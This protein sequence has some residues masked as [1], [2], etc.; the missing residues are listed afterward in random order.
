MSIVSSAFA[1]NEAARGGAIAF[2]HGV[3]SMS[4]CRLSGNQASVSGGAVYTNRATL[5][6]TN[7]TL[8]GNQAKEDGGAIDVMRSRLT[9]TSSSLLNNSAGYEGGGLKSWDDSIKI[10]ESVISGNTA[11]RDGGGIHSQAND[12]TIHASTIS[13]NLGNAGGGLYLTGGSHLISGSAFS[14]NRAAWYGGAI[15][16]EAEGITIENSTFYRNRAVDRVGGLYLRGASDLRH[17]T[18]ARN[19]AAEVGGL[20]LSESDADTRLVNSL[21]AGNSNGDCQGAFTA[22]INNLIED[23]TCNPELRGDARLA[24]LWGSP[25]AVVPADHSPAVDAGDP[26][27]CIDSDQLGRQRVWGASCDLG[28]FEVN[29][30]QDLALKSLGTT[31]SYEAP[32]PPQDPSAGIVVN[33]QCSLADAIKSAN[34]GWAV[35]GCPAGKAGADTITLT[36]NVTLSDRLPGIGSNITIEGAGHTISGANTFPIFNVYPGPLTVNDLTMTEG[37]GVGGVAIE[38]TDGVIT[39]NRSKII[40]N[41]S[42]GHILSSGGGIFCFPCTLIIRDS[43]I[44]NNSTETNGGG[45]AWHGFKE[46]EYLEIVDS[47]IDGNSARS[48][49]GLYISSPDTLQQPTIRNTTISNNVAKDDGGGIEAVVSTGMAYLDISHSAIIGNRAGGNGGGIIN[50]GVARLSLVTVAGNAADSGGGI[51]SAKESTTRLTH[52]TVAGNTADSG[53]GIYTQDEGTIQLRFSIIAGNSGNDCVGSPEHSIAG[54]IGDGSCNSMLKGDPLLA[55]LVMPAD[56]GPAYL[57]LMP[58]SPAIDAAFDAQCDGTDQI[59]R[60]RPQGRQCDL[61]AIEY[62]P[63]AEVSN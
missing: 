19:I 49:G 36:A 29:P 11:E 38:S 53:G 7:A 31:D 28:A 44:A 18:I 34:R 4:D 32:P 37:R 54:F 17:V 46:N 58:G 21:L 26:A 59:G 2:S 60:P 15:V 27:H 43:L 61:G 45:I 42:V 35:G 12:M 41:H 52:V 14:G 62:V 9:V 51:F 3:G 6:I 48:G 56:G 1:N 40:A 20:Y 22:N 10:S 50:H 13:D 25:P 23:G 57:P 47:V 8:E 30:S 33:E 63:N 24:G 55:D 16:I 39:V 5:T